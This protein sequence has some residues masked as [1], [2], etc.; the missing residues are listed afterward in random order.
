MRSSTTTTLLSLF[1]QLYLSLATPP[2]TSTPA[3]STCGTTATS[4]R[5]PLIV[6]GASA[7][8][9]GQWPWHASIWHRIT[10]TSHVYVCGGTLLSELYVLTS[11]HCVTK[12]GNALNERLIAVQLGSSRQNLLLNG[13]PVQN[14]DVADI[15]V[16]EDFVPR[17]FHADLALL[18]LGTKATVNEFVRPVCLPAAD[19][20][21][22]QL[23][24]RQAVALGFGMTETGENADGLRQLWMPVVDY[25]TCLESNREV[26][27]RSLSAAILCAGNTNGSTV[28]NGDS[29]G[30]LFT[31]EEGHWV[32][33]GVTSFTAQRGWNDSSCSL[34]DYAAFVNVAYYGGWIRHVV[35]NGEQD[36]YFNRKDPSV[37]TERKEP[38]QAKPVRGL[39]ISEKYC[40]MYRRKGLLVTESLGPGHVYVFKNRST[41]GLAYYLNDNFAIT[42]A[43]LAINCVYG[44]PACETIDKRRFKQAFVHPQYRGGRDF[45][46][47]LLLWP[48]A[49]EPLWCLATESSG[50][51]YFEGSQLKTNA[52]AA[53]AETWTEFDLDFFL[54]TKRGGVVYNERRDLVG[55]MHNPA[56]DEV[57]M[58]NILSVLDW[59]ESIAW[60][61]RS[62]VSPSRM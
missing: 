20:D 29:G 12:D 34:K 53:E 40:K 60:N 39:R 58:T 55:L 28:C 30:G 26:F 46:V 4:I 22:R 62:D 33:R 9:A 35:A 56:G 49:D 42:T 37:V 24:G 3:A 51:I 1:C 13:F 52:I 16:H 41:Q 6:N 2:P 36:G 15:F 7:T 45:N 48:P 23:D 14:V 32:I 59:I 43:Q 31:E 50:R 61:N 5:K 17:T 44:E 47:A 19:D 8:H 21:G 10:R 57:V 38:L 11:A 27:G 18:A 25:V 54:P